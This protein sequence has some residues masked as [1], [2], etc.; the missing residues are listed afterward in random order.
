MKEK[1]FKKQVGIVICISAL[2]LNMVVGHASAA[3]KIKK[4]SKNYMFFDTDGA[5]C[6]VTVNCTLKEEYVISS[7][8]VKYTDRMGYIGMVVNGNTGIYSQSAIK[9]RHFKSNGDVAKTFTDWKREDYI[10]PIG[11]KVLLCQ[12]SSTNVSYSKTTGKY[13]KMSYII[14][15][16]DFMLVPY[17]SGSI[18]M[19]LNIC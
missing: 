19:D 4:N 7:G 2:A 18:R 3:L 9:P 5:V 6:G 15:N 12:K 1:R 11:T 10:L 13:V 14:G 8:K 17:V 16:S